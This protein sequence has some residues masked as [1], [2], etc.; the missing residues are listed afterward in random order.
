MIGNLTVW[1]LFLAGAGAG[2]LAAAALLELR[3]PLEARTGAAGRPMLARLGRVASL[4]D[5]VI[6]REALRPFLGPAYGAGLAAM[7]VGMFCLMADLGRPDRLLALFLAPS[8][9]YIAVGAYLLVVLVLCA[10]PLVALW[11]FGAS[12]LPRWLIGGARVGCLVAAMAVMAYTGLFLSSL[13]AVVFWHSPWL[14]PL[15]VA[16][17][18]STGLGLVAGAV[19]LGPTPDA[20]RSTLRRLRRADA[21]AVGVEVVALVALIGA[22]LAEGGSARDAADVLLTGRLSPA[23]WAIA[24]VLGLVAPLAAELL[25]RDAT[26]RLALGLAACVLVGGLF[27]RWCVVQVGTTPDLAV[28]VAIALGMG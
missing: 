27:L 2:A 25:V 12:R 16:S 7:L 15:F 11:A 28:S 22:A 14:T 23:F 13:P 4:A 5:P 21:L 20:F 17:S 18:A 10:A 26:P 24:V 9:S 19:V 8:P 3:T 1:Y 6:P